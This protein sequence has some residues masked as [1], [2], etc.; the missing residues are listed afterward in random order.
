M[1]QKHYIYVIYER[2]FIKTGERIYKIGRT[3]QEPTDRFKGYPKGSQV[4]LLR[5]VSDSLEAENR[6][7]AE[8]NSSPKYKHRQDIGAEYY[9]GNVGDFIHDINEILNF[10]DGIAPTHIG[11]FWRILRKLRLY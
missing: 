2:E 10:M 8:L 7:K 11:M 6:I 4:V 5:C 1:E 9:Q 3:C